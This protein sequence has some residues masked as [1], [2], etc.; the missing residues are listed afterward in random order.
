MR[1]LSTLLLAL[2]CLISQVSA[3]NVDDIIN[4]HIQAMGGKE[5]LKNLKTLK[6]SGKYEIG[7]GMSVPFDVLIKNNK[8]FRFDMTLQGLTTTQ[9]L[10]GDS[11]YFIS[12]FEGKKDAEKM[13]PEM[14]KEVKDQLDVAGPLVDYKQ[15][16]NKVELI[17][18]EDMEGTETYKIRLTEKNGDVKYIFLDAQTYYQ[19]KETQKYK[20]EDKEVESETLFSNYKTVDGLTFPFTIESRSV[21]ESTGGQ[22]MN[23]DNIEVNGKFDEALFKWPDSVANP[24]NQTK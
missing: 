5:K 7:P 15:K 21:G 9:V 8:A 13:D 3:Q 24:V 18:K 1:Y 6:I 12:P 4:K 10:L 16:G 20:M 2:V 23:Y 22:I 11:G 14:I 17:G 19:L